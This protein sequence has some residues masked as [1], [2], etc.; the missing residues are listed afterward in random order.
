MGA[1][2]SGLAKTG[3]FPLKSTLRE[4]SA[5]KL[6]GQVGEDG[7]S[8]KVNLIKQDDGGSPIRHYLIKYR[9]KHSSDWKPEIRLPSGSDHVML[10]SLDWNSE[11][12]VFVIAENLQGKSKPA[13]YA[14]RTSAQ[15]TIIPAVSQA[16]ARRHAASKLVFPRLDLTRRSTIDGPGLHFMWLGYLD[17]ATSD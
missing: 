2:W 5:P 4:P 10:K 13:H 6:E 1:L 3:T 16:A 15:P 9:V 12:E 7:N 14:F 8:I 17:F 11:Y